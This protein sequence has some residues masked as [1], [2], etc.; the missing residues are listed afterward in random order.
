MYYFSLA[1]L[2][3]LNPA[4]IS[5]LIVLLPL[6]KKR[7][8]LFFYIGGAFFTYLLIGLVFFYGIDHYLE[9]FIVG[10]IE[11][12]ALI[13]RFIGISFGGGLIILGAFLT[14]QI[15]LSFKKPQQAPII[16]TKVSIK[17]VHPLILLGLSISSTLS[18]APTSIPYLFFISH[19][20]QEGNPF[21]MMFLHIIIYCLIY[22]LPMILLYTAYNIA[23]SKF[24]KIE[25][26][27]QKAM[28]LLSKYGFPLVSYVLGIW[29]IWIST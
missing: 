7:P 27:T 2:D 21:I 19:L 1:L 13:S 9:A 20:A 4:S 26:W 5:L 29:L 8:H 11:K 14:V 3:S 17:S 6:V 22:I 25:I 10:L 28:A 16:K 23:K 15:F 12:Y 18:D 24:D